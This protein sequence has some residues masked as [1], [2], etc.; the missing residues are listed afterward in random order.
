[1]LEE[2]G[3][4]NDP[5]LK[6]AMELE[7]IALQ[8]DYFVSKKLY[9][10]IDFYSGI[11]LRALGFP[12]SMFTA[13]FALARTVGWIAQWKEMLEDP[14]QKIGR[15][16]RS[17]RGR[18]IAITSIWR[19]AE[20]QRFARTKSRMAARGTQGWCLAAL[21]QTFGRFFEIGDLANPDNRIGEQRDYGGCKVF[22]RSIRLQE[23]RHRFAFEQQIH[24]R[25][26]R[27][28]EHPAAE[29]ISHRTQPVGR[30]ERCAR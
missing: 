14:H 20:I 16:G 22:R 2:V 9:P 30:D 29:R 18:R 3:H 11:T 10:N 7:R 6:V 4:Q 25:E 17:I 19:S 1:M 5:L 26:M 13:L 21:P 12:T 23:F 24:E 8:D 27:Q 15:R 28:L